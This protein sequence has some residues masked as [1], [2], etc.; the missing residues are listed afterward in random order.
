[1]LQSSQRMGE[2]ERANWMTNQVYIALGNILTV[3]AVEGIDSCP[4]EGFIPEQA[5]E[6]LNLKKI[7]LTSVLLLPVGFRHPEDSYMTLPKVRRPLDSI[8]N[9]L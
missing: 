7:G 4:M 5:D 9:Y 3:C 8:V 6:V 2:N 1:M